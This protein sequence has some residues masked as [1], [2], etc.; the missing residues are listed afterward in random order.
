MFFLTPAFDL[1]IFLLINQQLR[2]SLFDRIMPILSA[3]S[4]LLICVA[5]AIIYAVYRGGWKQLVLFLVLLAGM[6]LSDLT[7]NIVKKQI[8]RVRPYNALAQTHYHQDNQWSQRSPD[9]IRI[10]EQGRSYPS[11]HSSNMMCMAILACMLWPTLRKWPLVL[12][13]LTGYSRV[14]LGKHYPT[15]VLAGWV[16]GLVIAISVWLIWQYGIRRYVPNMD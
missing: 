7:T 12:P 1:K 15:D 10:K 5:V 4:I 9:F 16:F 14:Y 6:G 13:L 11:A 3:S 2:C 8:N